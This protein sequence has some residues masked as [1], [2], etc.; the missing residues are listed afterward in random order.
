M[1]KF[2]LV[3]IGACVDHADGKPYRFQ[4]IL[5]HTV[6]IE[7]RDNLCLCNTNQPLTKSHVTDVQVT[8]F[9]G[10]AVTG[11]YQV[12]GTLTYDAQELPH[13]CPFILD[14]FQL[15]V[16]PNFAAKLTIRVPKGDAK[17]FDFAGGGSVVITQ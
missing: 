15:K 1:N 5:D 3:L 11:I 9:T 17:V 6:D 4:C 10:D 12:K 14:V 8:D 2:S 16:L 13:N 7:D